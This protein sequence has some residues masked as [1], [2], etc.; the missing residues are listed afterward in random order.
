MN[1]FFKMI[2]QC[3][4]FKRETPFFEKKIILLILS[5]FPSFP[6]GE[7]NRRGQKNNCSSHSGAEM[8]PETWQS[9]SIYPNSSSLTL[10]HFPCSG[11]HGF[12]HSPHCPVPQELEFW[13]I[14][15]NSLVKAEEPSGFIAF[16][17]CVFT[18]KVFRTWMGSTAIP[19]Q[20]WEIGPGEKGIL[21]FIFIFI[22]IF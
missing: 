15:P 17:L 10:K 6:L 11:G 7:K 14:L 5:S 3:S 18:A 16:F 12:H 9:I 22:F 2:F 1:V 8:Q 13:N 20:P 19:G 21:I 4:D